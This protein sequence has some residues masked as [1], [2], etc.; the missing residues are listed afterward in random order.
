M[1]H[2]NRGGIVNLVHFEE[3]CIRNAQIVHFYFNEIILWK[4]QKTKTKKN[5]NESPT[6]TFLFLELSASPV[7]AAKPGRSLGPWQV[8]RPAF[9]TVLPE[10]LPTYHG[11]SQQRARWVRGCVCLSPPPSSGGMCSQSSSDAPFFSHLFCSLP[12]S[13]CCP[14]PP[15]FPNPHSLWLSPLKYVQCGSR[16]QDLHKYTSSGLF[17]KSV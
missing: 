6:S 7:P 15:A 9:G 8:L 2:V 16:T 1:C 11:S 3:L 5:A 14:L 13:L 17:G 4:S 10:V 12:P